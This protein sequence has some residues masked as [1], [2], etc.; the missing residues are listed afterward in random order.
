M[1]EV[2]MMTVFLKS[3]V[4]P[5]PSVSL[6]SSSICKR[7][8]KTSWWAFSISSK[9]MTEY[10]LLRTA[11][12]RYPP[13]SYPTYPGGAPIRRATECFSMNSLMSI[14]TIARSSSKRNSAKVFAVS[15]FPTPVGPRNI[16]DPMGLF[17]S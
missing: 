11:S 4:L 9:R 17:M 3:T 5:W 12:V 10:G 6:P 7:I 13:S 16:K 15:V 14:R 8:L 2:I 1:F